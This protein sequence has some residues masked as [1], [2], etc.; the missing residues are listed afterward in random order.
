MGSRG[1]D[2]R[3]AGSTAR[4]GEGARENG[5]EIRIRGLSKRFPRS[6]NLWQFLR[7]PFAREYVTALEGIDL[8]LEPGRIYGL[9]GPNGAGK[10]TLIKVIA[11]LVLP[12]TGD[13]SVGGLDAVREARAIR[14]RVGYVV[15]DERS[16]FWRLSVRENLRFFATLRSPS[17]RER[18]ERVDECLRRVRLEREA[19]RPFQALSTGMRQRLAIA[20]GL[21]SM[22]RILLLDEPTRSL[23][24]DAAQHVRDLMRELL[25]E[26]PGRLM[27]CS[28]HDLN[29]VREVCSHVLLIREGKLVLER[30]L[31][32]TDRDE[33]E[34]RTRT[35]LAAA[36]LVVEG[37][38]V[39][40]AEGTRALVRVRDARSLDAL[41]DR[42]RA[43]GA[44][45]VELRPG[46][47]SLEG[48]FGAR[49]GQS[50]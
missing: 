26:D 39:L 34:I 27:L 41:L 18:R 31:V 42:V 2:A 10:T 9:V 3:P 13:V 50:A 20:R 17:V 38:S 12:S 49:G 29:E 43:S 44:G 23:D 28:S 48:L 16:F 1:E 19:E 14:A 32:A 11:G 4:P 6:T 36:V 8:T 15:A 24:P 35:P 47:A 21:L 46:G 22:P 37:V 33:Y 30:A 40:R 7:R 45:L 25:A 5:G